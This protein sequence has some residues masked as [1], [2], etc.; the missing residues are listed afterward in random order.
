M[1]L[2]T[3]ESPKQAEMEEN[4]FVLYICIFA[5]ALVSSRAF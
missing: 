1:M 5:V 2:A 4:V 3:A